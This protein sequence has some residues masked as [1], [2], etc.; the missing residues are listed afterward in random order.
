MWSAPAGVPAADEKLFAQLF[1]IS[2]FPAV[3]SRLSDRHG[4][5]DQSA[6]VRA[7]RHFA[8]EAI[9]QPRHRLL[10]R[11]GRARAARGELRRGGRADNLRVQIRRPDGEP[12]LGACLR[13]VWSTTR[14]AGHPDRLHRHQRSGRRRGGAAGRANSGW[15]H[16]ATRSRRSRRATPIPTSGSTSGSRHPGRF[17]RDAAGRAGQHVAIRRGRSTIRCWGCTG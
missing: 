17:R 9:G 14:A 3:V 1:D 6:H 8:A 5:R 10:R 11:S 2:P 16:R 12:F 4:G 7:L 15:P 13:R